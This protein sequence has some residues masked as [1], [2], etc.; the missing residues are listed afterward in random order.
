MTLPEAHTHRSPGCTCPGVLLAGLQEYASFIKFLETKMTSF[1]LSLVF[2]GPEMCGYATRKVLS[3]Y[4]YD[5]ILPKNWSSAHQTW[6]NFLIYMSGNK[7]SIKKNESV[8]EE[9]GSW[10]PP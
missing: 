7:V 1:C 9:P 8:S 5:R 3:S 4:V 2:Q 10:Y 6:E